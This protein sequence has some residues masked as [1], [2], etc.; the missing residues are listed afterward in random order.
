MLRYILGRIAQ[1]VGVL[2][3]VFTATFVVLYLLPSN[4]VALLLA[5]GDMQADDLSPEQLAALEA[6]YGLDKPVYVQ[7]LDQ[8]WHLVR[9][10][11]GDSIS[12]HVPVSQLLDERLGSTIALGATAI[13]F[14]LVGG[15]SV[16]YLAAWVQWRPAKILLA[17]LPAI[18][19]SFPPFFVGLLLIQVFA[20]SLGWLPATGTDGWRSLILPA[21]M[22][23]A[24]TAAMLAQVLT[25]SLNDTLG[26]PYI[27]TARAKGLSRNAVQARHALRNAALPA[28][29]LLGLLLGATVTEAVVAET[30]FT[31]EGVGRLAQEAVLAQDVHVVQAIVLIAATV[32]VAINLVVDLIYPLL[33]PRVTHTQRVS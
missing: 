26:E 31:R 29:T 12:K 13:L 21:V 8:L 15:L 5:A 24:P 27:T 9:L 28:L 6:Q 11:F 14:T 20:F 23:S 30:V 22:M 10:D 25:R 33:D 1:A 4:P 32:F 3:A 2:W 18:G 16:A 7:Y 19:V 17:R